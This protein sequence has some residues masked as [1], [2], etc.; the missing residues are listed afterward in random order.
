[1]KKDFNLDILTIVDASGRMITGSTGFPLLELP[2]LR[3]VI[4]KKKIF[5]GTEV[6]PHHILLSDG[7]NLGEN[8]SFP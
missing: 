2:S 1:M 8:H 3:F 5:S 4:E 6:I 7:E